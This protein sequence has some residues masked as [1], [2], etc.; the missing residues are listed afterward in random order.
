MDDSEDERLLLEDELHQEGYDPMIRRV[1]TA[2]T[3]QAALSEKEWD[4]L[5]VDYVMPRFSGLAALGLYRRLELDLPVIVVSGQMGEEIAVEVMRAG[6]RD[7]IIKQ[8][9]S[10]LFPA[11]ARELGEY[12]DRLARREAEQKLSII[13]KSAHDAIVMWDSKGLIEFW[14]PAATRIF[15]WD[16]EEAI[17]I[18]I[19]RILIPAEDRKTAVKKFSFLTTA[20]GKMFGKTIELPALH[21]QGRQ[22]PIELSL[23]TF[24]SHGAQEMIGIARDISDRKRMEKAL[25]N[26]AT[27]DSLTGFYN[28]TELE[29]QLR[30]ELNR[31]LRH[32]RPLSVFFL[33]LDHFK[34]VNDRFGHQA[35][36]EL[37]QSFADLLRKAVRNVDYIGRY[38]GEEFVVILPETPPQQALETAKRLVGSVMAHRFNTSG[39]KSMALTVSIGISALP[40]HGVTV[41]GLINA[42]DKAMYTAKRTGRNRACL[43]QSTDG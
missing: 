9:R 28:R 31:A 41:E 17:G 8:N 22:F 25:K 12:G 23:S 33:D 2:E 36:D 14:N 15:G 4:L 32:Q 3:M 24:H 27:H 39:E 43:A 34:R 21:K 20:P 35:G 5:I 37:L 6:A 30:N 38:G 18:D 26:L 40:D 42:A 7:Y 10:R 13:A 16:E 1:E 29:A 11:I 19:Q